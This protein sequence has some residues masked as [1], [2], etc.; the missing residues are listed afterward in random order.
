MTEGLDDT[1]RLAMLVV[2]L[3]DQTKASQIAWDRYDQRHAYVFS[4]EDASVV[5]D[6][7]DDDGSPPYRIRVFNQ[8][9]VAVSSAVSPQQDGDE[10]PFAELWQLA[11]RSALK[12][13]ETLDGL[14]R[15]LGGN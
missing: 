15:K 4:T 1:G 11:R 13:D 5:V 10:H 3:L 6:T 2:R 14:L 12:V 8:D 7:R 9:G